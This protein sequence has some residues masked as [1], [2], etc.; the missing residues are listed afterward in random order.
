MQS[1]ADV[2]PFPFDGSGREAHDP[3]RLRLRQPDKK[4]QKNDLVFSRI[5]AFE[6]RQCVIQGQHVLDRRLDGNGQVVNESDK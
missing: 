3:S 6:L 2:T 4:P 5:E 1:R